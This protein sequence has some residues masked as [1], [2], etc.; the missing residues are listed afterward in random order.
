MTLPGLLRFLDSIGCRTLWTP[1]SPRR[2]DMGRSFI[3]GKT[4]NLFDTS[5]LGC[6]LFKNFSWV[7]GL[8]Q[9]TG[10]LDDTDKQ[11]HTHTQNLKV[12]EAHTSALNMR[13]EYY[14]ISVLRSTGM[15]YIPT[16]TTSSTCWTPVNCAKTKTKWC[17]W[18]F[19][20]VGRACPH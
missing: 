17:T 3:T 7:N 16:G 8:W 19:K 5:Q 2:G 12:P 10:I 4:L 9:Q 20:G 11:T 18:L 14:N 15:M 1:T 13:L 6:C